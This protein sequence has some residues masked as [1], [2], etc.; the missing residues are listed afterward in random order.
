MTLQHCT[1]GPNGLL[2][3][4]LVVNVA[5]F[6][7]TTPPTHMTQKHNVVKKSGAMSSCHMITCF[8]DFGSRDHW[9]AFTAPAPRICGSICRLTCFGEK[10]EVVTLV[11]HSSWPKRR[12]LSFT[13]RGCVDVLVSCWSVADCVRR[14]L[15]VRFPPMALCWQLVVLTSHSASPTS[16]RR[17]RCTKWSVM[18]KYVLVCPFSF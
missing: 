7:A 1:V 18:M 17:K 4:S 6:V 11:W 2:Q 16:S 13:P 15:V 8:C 9:F 10:A 5:Y 12:I 3:A 14:F